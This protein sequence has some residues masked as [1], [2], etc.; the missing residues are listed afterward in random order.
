MI[1]H[2]QA[3]W[4]TKTNGRTIN[5]IV[6]HSMEAPEKGQTAENCAEWFRRGQVKASAHECIDID[7]VVTCVFA[8]DVAYAAPGANH[9]GYHLEHAGYA[10]QSREEWLDPYGVAMLDLSAKRA[11][12]ACRE[13][14]IP[15]RWLSAEDMKATP[16]AKGI[17]SHWN[18]TLAFGRSDHTDPG[19]HFPVDWYL[20][21]I[22]KHLAPSQPKPTPT[23]PPI[24]RSFIM[25]FVKA[26]NNPAVYVTDGVTKRWI[27]DE[28]E[29][30]VLRTLVSPFVPDTTIREY[31]TSLLARIVLVGPPPPT[32]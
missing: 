24:P 4:Y 32:E 14:D 9:D 1:K 12:L 2:V 6:V 18:V 11:A 8:K 26:E 22:R 3:K 28:N 30:E 13:F 7:S 10:R 21:R 17:T 31:P 20:E 19:Q 16:H 27:Q 25:F 5:K 15:V 23:P 29:L